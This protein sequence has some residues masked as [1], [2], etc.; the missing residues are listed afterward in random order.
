MRYIIGE[1]RYQKIMFPDLIDEYIT[2]ENPVRV[3]DAYVDNL[4]LV[5]LGI[6]ATDNETGRPPYNPKD[7]LKLFI[8]GYLNRLRSSRK[9]ET[10]SQRN[11]ELMWLINKLS[12]DHKTIAEFRRNNVKTLKNVFL[13]FVKFCNGLGLYGLVLAAVD[14]SKFKAV[15][16]K[17]NNFNNEKLDDKIHRIDDKIE[18][19]LSELDQNDNNEDKDT[20]PKLTKEEI[21]AVVAELQT[22]KET[23]NNM[24]EQLQETGQTQI[25]T[26]DPDSKRMKEADGGSDICF[27]VQTAVDDKHKLIIDYEVTNRCNDKNLLA[28]M[29]K[30][31]K[32]VLGVDELAVTAD[33]GYFVASDLAECIRNGI[34][35]H[36]SSDYES[37]TFCVPTTEEEATEPAEF[38]NTGKNVLIED[39]NVGVCPMGNVLYPQKYLKSQ[40]IAVYRNAQAC[41]NCPHKSECTTNNRRLTVQMPESEFSTEYNDEN[42]HF[43]QITYAPDKNLLRKRKEIV[44]HPFGTIKQSMDSAHCLLKGIPK[45]R[46]EFALT[47]LAYNMK[48]VI[49]IVGAAGLLKA[50]RG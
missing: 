43:K 15:N 17:E 1:D 30:S 33:T 2:A 26:T 13:D 14:G 6:G 42:L 49:N 23:Y 40:N 3:L 25:S 47:F 10:E 31:A 16:S 19:Y 21:E 20:V 27:N 24:K 18:Q 4:D 28:P 29:A 34:T 7:M 32:D 35:P 44:E 37:V 8:Y 50:I 46:A 22:R 9:L 5:E 12:P 38:N 41:K 39:R 11:V 36:V 45:V 48:R